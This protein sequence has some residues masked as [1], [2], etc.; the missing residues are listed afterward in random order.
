MKPE[1]TNFGPQSGQESQS[2]D[3]N[4][5][6]SNESSFKFKKEWTEKIIKLGIL[7]LI[8]FVLFLVGRAVFVWI[9]NDYCAW[10]ATN[11]WTLGVHIAT[12]VSVDK[13]LGTKFSSVAVVWAMIGSFIII[14]VADYSKYDGFSGTSDDQTISELPEVRCYYP[15]DKPYFKLKDGQ[16]TGWLNIPNNSFTQA[17]WYITDDVYFVDANGELTYVS[18]GGEKKLPNGNFKIQALPDSEVI[19]EIDIQ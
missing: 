12:L 14:M 16:T 1:K 3:Q 6:S 2:I 11:L 17:T 5:Q 10:W 15:G 18:K 19:I 9:T 13:I 4:Q 8:T 7:L